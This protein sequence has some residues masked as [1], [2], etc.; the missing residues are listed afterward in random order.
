MSDFTAPRAT[1]SFRIVLSK[2]ALTLE[3]SLLAVA[4]LMLAFDPAVW[5]LNS[6]IDPAYDSSGSIVFVIVT[7]LFLWSLTSRLQATG[8]PKRRR[9]ALALL[10]VSAVIRLASQVLAVNTIGALCLVV[11]VYAVALLCRLDQRAR[12]VSPAWLAV[13][14]AFCLPL[15]RIVQRSV[16]FGLQELAA[17]GACLLLSMLYRDLVCNGVRLILEGVD[18]LVDLPCSGA[19]TLLLG[20]F[21]FSVAA[22]FC[23]P[24]A[25]QAI[26]GLVVTLL[27]AIAANMMRISVL[28]IGIA[29]PS[30]FGGANVMEQPWH[31]AIGLVALS[32]VGVAIVFWSRAIRCLANNPIVTDAAFA[33]RSIRTS[34]RR[35]MPGILIGILAIGLAFAITSLPRTPLDV[36]QA[37]A[38]PALPLALDGQQRRDILLSDRERT[39]FTRFGGWAAKA[40]YGP[41]GL[42]LVHTTSP[43]RHLHAPDECLRGL[44]YDVQ[45]LG[46]VFE[47]VATAIYRATAPDGQRY[48]IEVSFVSDQGLVVTNVSTAVWLWLQGSASSWTAVQ[49]I[50]PAASPPDQQARFNAAAIAAL[51]L[52]STREVFK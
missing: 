42:M 52:E 7:G 25:G 44:G 49:R 13:A 14:F 1:P 22:A 33:D 26:T 41:F 16:G 11:D 10:G 32:V 17:D 35:S 50:A 21:G 30:R 15:E 43:L 47:P 6:W 18:I 29:E 27:A 39:F 24:K 46:S 3:Y 51:D 23:R 40:E 31:D 34:S 28:A 36:A 8:D 38:P 37:T 45:Y 9:L 4:A 12:S 5:L 2:L 19:R 48:R 20:L